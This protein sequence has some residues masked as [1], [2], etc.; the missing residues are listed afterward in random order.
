MKKY[1]NGICCALILLLM[2]AVVEITP[3]A[4]ELLNSFSKTGEAWIS[5]VLYT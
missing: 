1:V 5:D 4:Y 3:G 2:A